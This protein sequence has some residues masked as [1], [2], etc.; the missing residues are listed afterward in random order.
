M[1]DSEI[2]FSDSP[3]STGMFK[4]VKLN[5]ILRDAMTAARRDAAVKRKNG[6]EL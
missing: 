6:V 2:D 3:E 5:Q 4:S 1:P